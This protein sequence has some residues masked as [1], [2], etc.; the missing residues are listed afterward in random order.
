MN[1][2]VL[3]SEIARKYQKALVTGGAG[4]IGSHIVEELLEV[5]IDV[6]SVDD[7]VAGKEENIAPFY[8]NPHF[9]SFKCDVTDLEELKKC[10]DGVDIVFHEAASKKNVCL[11]DPRRDLTVNGGG[12]FNIL[13][14]TRDLK[15]KKI[16]HA[17]TGSVYGEAQ[18]R[19][20]TEEH[21][22]CP[23]SYYGV[24]K[25]A[26]ERYVKTF[27]QLYDID[28]SILRYFHVYGPRQESGKYGGVIAIFARQLLNNMHPTIFGDGTQERSFTYVKD[29]VNANLFVAVTDDTKGEVYNCASGINVTVGQMCDEM[30]SILNKEELN[31]EYYD[32]TI[33]DIKKVSISNDKLCKMG[34][35]FQTSF[36][37]GLKET[38]KSFEIM[39]KAGK[40]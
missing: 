36:H 1:V 7:F 34:F 6:V 29:V 24:S 37:E 33:G 13:E 32:W 40:I 30:R 35:Q 26:G 20:Q 25:L 18:I 16:V 22:L 4:F 8:S 23:V 17:S 14:L 5:G 39:H 19:P 9:K 3:K 11:K 38:V 27:E 31:P 21:P 12:T 2:S 15:V 28:A 10:F